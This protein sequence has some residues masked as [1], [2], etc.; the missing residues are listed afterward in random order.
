MWL[1]LALVACGTS[2]PEVDPANTPPTTTSTTEAG[3]TGPSARHEAELSYWPKRTDLELDAELRA[4][5]AASV[6]DGKPVLIAFSAPWCPDC[7]R[8]RDL[9]AE[10]ALKSEQA[11]WHKLVVDVGRFDQH[12]LLLGAFSL[13]KI[14]TWVALQPTDCLGGPDT[15][16]VLR[17][18]IFEP[19]TGAGPKTAESLAAWL[20][21]ARQP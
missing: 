20:Q 11:L 17:Q 3:S 8:V 10:P 18:S 19:A 2:A 12:E 5:C 14:V 6:S 1:S 7:R 15:W 4:A 16:P 13:S 9:E 21:E